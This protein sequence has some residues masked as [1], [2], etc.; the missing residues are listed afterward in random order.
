MESPSEHQKRTNNRECYT[1]TFGN[2]VAVLY[3][4]PTATTLVWYALE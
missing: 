2:R 3:Q 4:G 1:A